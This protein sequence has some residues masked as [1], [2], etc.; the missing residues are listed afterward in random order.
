MKIGDPPK[1]AP[2]SPAKGVSTVKSARAPSEASP[3]APA[4]EISLLGV[5]E[6]EM[7]PRVREALMSLLGELAAIAGGAFRHARADEGPRNAGRPRSAS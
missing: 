4:D 5:P 1:S 6:N 7:T 3:V 2:A